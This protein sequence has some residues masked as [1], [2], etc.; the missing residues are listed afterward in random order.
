MTRPSSSI[1][2]G[3]SV[4]SMPLTLQVTPHERRVQSER[5]LPVGHEQI[6]LQP[7]IRAQSVRV[8]TDETGPREMEEK[9]ISSTSQTFASAHLMYPGIIVQEQHPHM[10]LADNDYSFT[11]FTSPDSKGLAG[12]SIYEESMIDRHNTFTA[13]PRSEERSPS[14]AHIADFHHPRTTSRQEIQRP[15]MHHDS[16][17]KNMNW[18]SSKDK[19]VV[20]TK[21]RYGKEVNDRHKKKPKSTLEAFN[22]FYNALGDVAKEMVSEN[23]DDRSSR[24]YSY[25]ANSSYSSSF[26][27]GGDNYND[28]GSFSDESSRPTIPGHVKT[29]RE[30]MSVHEDLTVNSYAIS[31]EARRRS[32]VDRK[33][34]SYDSTSYT[35]DDYTEY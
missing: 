27:D 6:V 1:N 15:S 31:L 13:P 35:D 32:T 30:S 26:S 19:S 17:M 23:R 25:S 9:R 10:R 12:R 22:D 29:Q 4:A 11:S 20:R 3:K 14:H 21:N 28:E 7:R 34:G 24:S 33:S 8:F 16:N 2:R 5:L 18:K